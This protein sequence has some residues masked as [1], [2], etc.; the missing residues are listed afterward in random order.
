MGRVGLAD[1]GTTGTQGGGEI[2]AGDTVEGEGKVIWAE[3][4]NRT[5]WC[6]A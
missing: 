1:D 5:D 4:A 3:Y 2:T 6:K